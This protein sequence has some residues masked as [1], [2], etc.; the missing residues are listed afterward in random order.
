M[1]ILLD[2]PPHL[3]AYN[4]EIR[5]RQLDDVLC[6]FCGKKMNRHQYRVRSMFWKHRFHE[7]ILLRMR[8]T[9]CDRTHTMFPSFLLPWRRFANHILEFLGRML[10]AGCPL[11]SLDEF[12]TSWASSIVSIRTLWRWK[13]KLAAKWRTWLETTRKSIV[14][15]PGWDDLWVRSFVGDRD[16]IYEMRLLLAFFFGERGEPVPPPGR[17]LDRLNLYLPPPERM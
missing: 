10:L 8:C 9:P 2:Y 15:T 1:S 7:V 13:K 12:L 6:P 14:A 5:S 4:K 16:T 17:I 3:N 11:T